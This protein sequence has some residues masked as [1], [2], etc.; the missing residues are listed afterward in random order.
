[1]QLEAARP[2]A[3][4]CGTLASCQMGILAGPPVQYTV[5]F[6]MAAHVHE[7]VESPHIAPVTASRCPAL[8]APRRLYAVVA[9]LPQ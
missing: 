9:I 7:I 4:A 2:S 8:Y 6:T 1:M 3:A 5:C